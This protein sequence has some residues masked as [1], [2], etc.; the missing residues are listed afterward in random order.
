M[1]PGVKVEGWLSTAGD[2]IDPSLASVFTWGGALYAREGAGYFVYR[3]TPQQALALWIAATEA[4]H[5]TAAGGGA[6][7]QVDGGNYLDSLDSRAQPE[8]WP[9]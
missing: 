9:R 6:E 1:I 8:G 5:E 7:V 4:D 3:V 2:E